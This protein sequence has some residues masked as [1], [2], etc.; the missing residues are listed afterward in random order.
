M[1]CIDCGTKQS[2]E[3][4]EVWVAAA[5]PAYVCEYC[6]N[7][8]KQ[9]SEH[10]HGYQPAPDFE[11]NP[12]QFIVDRSASTLAIGDH[13]RMGDMLIFCTADTYKEVIL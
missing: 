9:Q 12:K 4:Y 8:R 11:H 5:A 3:W 6:Q 13:F 2:V 7:T 1:E 10:I